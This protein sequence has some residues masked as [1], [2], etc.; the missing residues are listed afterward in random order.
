MI[1]S[2]LSQLGTIYFC[3]IMYLRSGQYCNLVKRISTQLVR[4][5]I[6]EPKTPVAPGCTPGV[7]EALTPGNPRYD[8]RGKLRIPR[9]TLFMYTGDR[10]LTIHRRMHASLCICFV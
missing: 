5:P 10:Q 1:Q 8:K 6:F 4:G 3:P 2:S 9:V 7:R